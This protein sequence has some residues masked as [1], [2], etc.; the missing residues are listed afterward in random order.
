M[1]SGFCQYQASSAALATECMRGR[2]KAKMANFWPF[3][4]S[5]CSLTEDSALNVKTV[6]NKTAHP[7]MVARAS[8]KAAAPTH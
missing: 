6:T 4:W 3:S 2:E 8:L 7:E 1:E 5:S